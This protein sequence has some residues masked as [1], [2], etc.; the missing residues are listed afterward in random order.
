MEV[1]ALY[2][3][4]LALLLF[5]TGGVTAIDR[6]LERLKSEVKTLRRRL[7]AVENMQKSGA[8]EGDVDKEIMRLY[9]EG[10]SVSE[11]AEELGVPHML[12]VEKLTMAL[13]GSS[14]VD[15]ACPAA[16]A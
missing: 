2:A 7:E 11:I 13:E 4:V 15:P 3:I 5:F 9:E 1:V 8:V 12:V 14:N 10:R 16:E 6:E